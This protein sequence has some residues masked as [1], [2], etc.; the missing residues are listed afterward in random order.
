MALALD[1]QVE[2]VRSALWRC[3]VA[4][5]PSRDDDYDG[6]IFSI[7]AV[8]A[9]HA[10]IRLGNTFYEIDY[11]VDADCVTL[12]ERAQWRAVELTWTPSLEVKSLGDGRVGAYLVLFGSAEQHDL[13]DARDYFTKSTDFWLDRW[14]T[15]PM[16]YDHTLGLPADF[17]PV[18]GAWTTKTIDS[19]GVWAEGELEKAHKY[20]AMIQRLIDEGKLKTSSDSAPHLVRRKRAAKNTH[21]VVRWPLLAGSLTTTP[22]EP[23]LLP[24]A[25]IKSAY[26][27]LGLP[28]P[29]K[30]TTPMTL[31][32]LLAA[33]KTA[34]AKGDLDEAAQL[35]AQAEALEKVQALE[36]KSAGNVPAAQPVRPPFAGD[37]PTGDEPA[38]LSA[39]VKM[40]A[41]KRFGEIDS[42]CKQVSRE[43]YGQDYEQIAYDKNRD[44]RRYIKTGQCD[45]KLSR[46]LLLT[47]AQIAEGAE[48]YTVS[49][50]KATMVEA[51]DELGGYLVPEDRRQ[52]MI[53]RLPGMTAIRP[54][55]TVINTVR[56]RVTA[57]R[58]TGGNTRYKGATR[59]KWVNEKPT[60]GTAQ[61][62]MTFEEIGIPIH[63]VMVEV[64][65]SRNLLE[66]AGAN[67]TEMLMSEITT[68]NAL[69]EDEQFLTG[70]G[71]GK[72][73]GILNG[74]GANGAPFDSD[75]AIVN[76]GNAT[77]LTA[78][79]LVNVPF[80]IAAQYRQ[81][82]CSWIFNRLTLKDIALLKDS[83][84]RY[85][86]TDNNNQLASSH[87]SKLLGYDY[88]EVEVM[89]SIA[90]N[91]YPVLFG[92][93]KG[94]TIA[95]RI[96]LAIERYLDSSTARENTVLFIARRRLGG[97]VTAGWQ[98][99][100]QKVAA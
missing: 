95:D 49:E 22:A 55:A 81:S 40:F 11:T 39:S 46:T 26:K 20:K 13:S 67:L 15:I 4:L 56:D 41:I 85:L 51:S 3:R 14:P 90:A 84:N 27:A 74:T 7:E 100:A 53:E 8:Y 1:Q 92:N 38:E 66:D 32:E 54:K 30:E 96:G 68:A 43:L 82:G 6:R 63:T 31:Q 71:V 45:A 57:I 59:V 2:A 80:Q 60:A 58:P 61:S 76:S 87:G 29:L 24:V 99:A 91:K 36:V 89:P 83:Q 52:E 93:W 72:P 19:I 5:R 12:A 70:N 77:V 33:A 28:E 37:Q 69:D 50:V 65:L 98:I 78:D 44:F 23:R 25:T 64:F 10:V 86:F 97:D 75:I 62:N 16:L 18:V 88:D 94:Y 42:A 79:G 9:T 48:D 47:P 34:I 35:T 21:E 17:E 73:R